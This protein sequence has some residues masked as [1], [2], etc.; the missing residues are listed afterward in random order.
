REDFQVRVLFDEDFWGRLNTTGAVDV[1][2]SVEQLADLVVWAV[3]S[4]NEHYGV[5]QKPNITLL[6]DLSPG[7][8][9]QQLLHQLPT[10]LAP[11]LEE[12]NFKAIW[13]VGSRKEE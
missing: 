6:L 1:E 4:K 11:K 12:V 13:L 3:K 2:L 8:I 7:T 10:L 9:Y 5:D